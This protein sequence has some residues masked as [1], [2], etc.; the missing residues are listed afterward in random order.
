MS[1]K[2]QRRLFIRSLLVL[3]SIVLVIAACRAPQATPTSAPPEPTQPPAQPTSTPTE[4]VAEPATEEGPCLIVGAIYVGPVTDAGFNQVQ[5][6]GLEAIKK[7]IP[8]V[9]TI[10]AE[11]VYES[12]EAEGVME[13]MIQQGAGLIFATSF[14]HMEPAF[15]VA[16][17]HPDVIFMHS[18]GYM[19]SDNFGTYFSKMPEALYPMGVAAAKMTKTGKI[20]YV[21]AFP[22][23]FTLA[24]V[25]AFALGAQS[26]NPDIET[27]VVFTF[28]WV[29]RAKEAAATNALL[30]QGVDVVTM[31]VDSPV[32]I[33]ETAEAGGAYSIG[34]QSL[35]TQEYAPNGW[36]TGLAFNWEPVMTETAQ[37]VLDGT[38]KSQHIRKG[39]GEG[40]MVIAPFGS[41]VPEDVQKLVLDVADQ[42]GKGELNV[43]AGPLFDQ[44]GTVRVAEGEA[45]PEEALGDFDWYVQGVIGEPPQ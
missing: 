32:T 17:K 34:F 29:D 30:D 15:N 21:G 4:A 19:L 28:S 2:E 7:N 36:I 41:A 24:N 16:Q 3:T 33:I 6:E 27:H 9:E 35:A 40:Y 18:G 43:F 5:H 39:L 38:W 22:I 25:N 26:V 14:G 10:E 8:C 11:N 23:G 45:W 1:G 31:H 42:I 20:G 13:N 44:E 12:S 37:Q